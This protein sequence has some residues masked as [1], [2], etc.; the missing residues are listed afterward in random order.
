M[1]IGHA[2]SGLRFFSIDESFFNNFLP[3]SN[4]G[5][6]FIYMAGLLRTGGKK[7]NNNG[8]RGS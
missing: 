1:F 8:S 2:Q 7:T 3:I 4:S 5:L 6:D